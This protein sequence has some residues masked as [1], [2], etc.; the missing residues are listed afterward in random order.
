MKKRSIL[1]GIATVLMAGGLLAGCGNQK[2]SSS[3]SNKVSFPTSYSSKGELKK[4]GTLKVGLVDDSPF[5]GIFVSELSSDQ[6]TADAA[7]FGEQNLFKTNDDNQFIN[8]GAANIKFDNKAKTATITI[9]TKV[10][11][12]DGQPVTSRDVQFS[13]EIIANK[14][15]NSTY[16]TDDMNDIIGMKEYHEG[17]ASSISGLETP[18]DHT[19][20]VHF[21]EMKPSMKTAGNSYIV[22][23]AQPYHY[24]K[25]I[26]MGKLASSD[27]AR[28][29]PL[30]YGPFKIQK[31][32]QGESIEWVPNPYYWGK[33]PN[34]SKIDLQIVSSSQAA[35]S[36]KS[37]KFDVLL[38]EPASVYNQ[39]KN[40]GSYVTLGNKN[41][42]FS[43]LGFKVGH[44]D[45]NGNSVMDKNAVTQNKALRQALAYAMNVDQIDKKLGYGVSYRAN[46]V[47]PEAFKEYH[48]SSLKGFPYNIK[49]AN[50]L[51]DNA[52]FKKGKDGYRT[53]PNGKKLT[54]TLLASQGSSNTEATVQNYIQQWKK[55]GVRV[56]LYNGR[57][58]EFNT[59]NDKLLNGASGYDMW[60]GAWAT[61]TDPD[62][63]GLYSSTAPYNYG[64]FVTQEN[65]DLLNS[66]NSQ[67]AFNDSYRKQQFYKWQAYMNKEA[68]VIPLNYNYQTVPVSK[69]VKNFT[70][71]TQKGYTLWENVGLTK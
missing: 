64:H 31:I 39:T 28:T 1:T 16:Y 57:L 25:D 52:G 10:K 24:L 44:A 54:L 17:K 40:A 53:Q 71:D 48:D 29:K 70:L 21:K 4:G 69:K 63:S 47:I 23:D 3:S 41:H 37:N 22:T 46:T 67:K 33:K 14:D 9:N 56:K 35:E 15:S 11:W 38:E 2:Q 50:Q 68:F 6:P 7:Q 20:V 62:P 19:L 55:I 26:P 51:L 30:F 5:K 18:N 45:A 36:L 65:T 12:S 32:V 34:L 60:L 61:G 27:K 8:G 49:K 59:F 66:L 42:Y 13:Y 58:Q 43:Y